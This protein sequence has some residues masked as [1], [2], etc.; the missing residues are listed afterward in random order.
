MVVGNFSVTRSSINIICSALPFS[1]EIV[2][3]NTDHSA[4]K[5]RS[6][7]MVLQMYK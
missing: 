6:T 5:Y 2:V 4:D 3:M 7:H 1:F